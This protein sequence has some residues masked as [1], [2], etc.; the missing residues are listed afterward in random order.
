MRFR[1][2][3][4]EISHEDLYPA[5]FGEFRK[6]WLPYASPPGSYYVNFT[7]HVGNTLDRTFSPKPN[8]HDPAG[9]YGYPLDYVLNHPADIEY[10]QQ[11][12]YLRVIQDTSSHKLVL[13]TLTMD[14][15]LRLLTAM[16]IQEPEKKMAHMGKILAHKAGHKVAVAFFGVVQYYTDVGQKKCH[17]NAEQ[18]ALLLKA[19]IDALE[20]RSTGKYDAVIYEAEPEQIVFMKRSAFK[21]ID[22]YELRSNQSVNVAKANPTEMFRR[23]PALIAT[24]LGDRIFNAHGGS[25]GDQEQTYYTAKGIKIIVAMSKE[26]D[27][28]RSHREG[29]TNSKH[30]LTV[31]LFGPDFKPIVRKYPNDVTFTIIAVDMREQYDAREPAENNPYSRIKDYGSQADEAVQLYAAMA[32]KLKLPFDAPPSGSNMAYLV[33]AATQ[34]IG[35]YTDY[36]K[37]QNQADRVSIIIKKFWSNYRS[38]PI[39]AEQMIAIWA[40]AIKKIGNTKSGNTRTLSGMAA[41]LGITVTAPD[42]KTAVSNSANGF[43][44]EIA[45]TAIMAGIDGAMERICEIENNE[46]TWHTPDNDPNKFLPYAKEVVSF[47]NKN[48]VSVEG[49]VVFLAE[50]FGITFD[51]KTW[52]TLDESAERKSLSKDVSLVTLKTDNGSTLCMQ[53]NTRDDSEKKSIAKRSL[54][55]FLSFDNDGN[56]TSIDR[57]YER[58]LKF[59]LDDEDDGFYSGKKDNGGSFTALK[60][61]GFDL[62]NYMEK[63]HIEF[64]DRFHGDVEFL[65]IVRNSINGKVSK[66]VSDTLSPIGQYAGLTIAE[67]RVPGYNRNKYYVTAEDGWKAAFT[68]EMDY[69]VG[70]RPLKIVSMSSSLS[71]EQRKSVSD[72]I[73]SNDLPVPVKFR[74]W[75]K[76]EKVKK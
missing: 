4:T 23:L 74:P 29:T 21:V 60:N 14:E 75:L 26:Y 28:L 11:A 10:G 17:T 56:L 64:S 37:A 9:L 44:I 15:A 8:H 73:T 69:Q 34:K 36:T 52:K 58:F 16:G 45:G 27:F 57:G 6:K 35:S 2:I 41:L 32:A 43:H 54:L 19:G 13:Q 22:V 20:D 72:F 46:T 65:G 25:D 38:E 67:Y 62:M 70:L 71:P 7:D 33:Y 42:T 24:A 63:N 12:K 50:H 39:Q 31:K 40:K 18:S 55:P 48:A 5:Q 76:V 51:G 61:A 49:Y 68:A 30:S 47:L 59:G 66:T 3:L 1:E 53:N